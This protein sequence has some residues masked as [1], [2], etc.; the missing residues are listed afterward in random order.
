[1]ADS[2]PPLSTQTSSQKTD[3]LDFDNDFGG[4]STARSRSGTPQPISDLEEGEISCDSSDHETIEELN[5]KRKLLQSILEEENKKTTSVEKEK[6]RDRHERTYNEEDRKRPY[7]EKGKIRDRYEK[8]TESSLKYSPVAPPT[9]GGLLAECKKSK[10]EKVEAKKAQS[11]QNPKSKP[12]LHNDNKRNRSERRSGEHRN[13]TERHSGEDR[14]RPERRSIDQKNKNEKNQDKEDTRDKGSDKFGKKNMSPSQIEKKEKMQEKVEN[15][16]AKILVNKKDRIH[17]LVG[18]KDKVQVKETNIQDQ[19]G[20]KNGQDEA[21]DKKPDERVDISEV[22]NSKQSKC[23]EQANE[24]S[25]N[26]YEHNEQKD[27]GQEDKSHYEKTDNTIDEIMDNLEEMSCSS[28]DRDNSIDGN[29]I[30]DDLGMKRKHSDE[31]SPANS[32]KK[33]DQ[34]ERPTKR[35]KVDQTDDTSDQSQKQDD[36]S[37]GNSIV[38][39]TDEMSDSNLD[40][41]KSCPLPQEFQIIDDLGADEASKASDDEVSM[42]M[43]D[44]EYFSEDLDD[45]E[46]YAWLEEGVSKKSMADNDSDKVV[47]VDERE[48]F[49]LLEKGVDPFEVLPEGWVAVTHNS[50]MPAYLHKA[51]RVCTLSKPYFLGPGSVRKHDIPLSAIPCLQYRKAMDRDQPDKDTTI[52]EPAEDTE[53]QTVPVLNGETS[54]PIKENGISEAES[55]GES[56]DV[57]ET[58]NDDTTDLDRTL[59]FDDKVGENSGTDVTQSGETTKLQPGPPVKIE[60]A[61]QRKKENSLSADDVLEYCKNLFEFKTVTVKKF[62]TWKE[63]RKH[64]NEMRKQTRPA[65][66]AN[67]TLI[68]CSITAEDGSE[69][70]K[71]K[72]FVLNPVGKSPVCILH[73]YAQHTLKVQPRY[74]F[75]ELENAQNPYC[76]TVLINNIEYGKGYASSKKM[77]KVNAAKATLSILIPQMNKVNEE[78]GREEDLSFF[79]EIKIE[80]PRVSDLCTK[81]GQ[82]SPYQLLLEC[83]KRNYGM[84]DTHVKTDVTPLRHQKSEYTL[85]VGKHSVTIVCKNKREGKQR[86]AQA[87]LQQLHTHITSLGSLLRLYGQT[88]GKLFKD[89]KKE[90]ESITELQTQTHSNK[91]N[92]ALLDKLRKEMVKLQA[93]RKSLTSKGSLLIDKVPGGVTS[94]DL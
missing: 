37:T 80:D 88:T 63:R 30:K 87:M 25:I 54:S 59:T 7:V 84:G 89:K 26:D 65:L 5:E 86:A 29:D 62:K 22:N 2:K 73:E 41:S 36:P 1:M 33:Q 43:E 38:D 45:S 11:D 28:S 91:P 49:V 46:I 15:G 77:A 4:K 23:N 14:T 83:L 31:G 52:V 10:G 20:K 8:S 94:L 48:K 93:Q 74:S 3:R 90:E 81:T 17:I 70:P 61:E 67:T 9:L 42:G 53:N 21:K 71:K 44:G 24:S 76:A 92:T 27:K 57:R 68:T 79:D 58:S 69:K 72:E 78:M 75:Q 34:D 82:P 32:E 40:D 56:S 66:P 51:S 85:T 35:S 19:V 50:G 64:L 12:S 18:Q 6:D 47:P 55:I 60:S 16:K 39:N 13:R